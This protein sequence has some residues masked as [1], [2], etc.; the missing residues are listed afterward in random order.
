MGLWR[1]VTGHYGTERENKPLALVDLGQ[2]DNTVVVI[3]CVVQKLVFLLVLLKY[4]INMLFR[5]LV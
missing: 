5:L 3:V 4:Q 2:A 1:E